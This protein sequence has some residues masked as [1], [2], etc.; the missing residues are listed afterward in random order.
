MAQWLNPLCRIVTQHIFSLTQNWCDGNSRSGFVLRYR[1]DPLS[2]CADLFFWIHTKASIQSGNHMKD[3]LTCTAT[4]MSSRSLEGMELISLGH[5][6]LSFASSLCPIA[7]LCL[8][9][10]RLLA[11]HLRYLVS[12]CFRY[13]P[14][15]RNIVGTSWHGCSG[16]VRVLMH[17]ILHHLQRCFV[18]QQIS[19]NL[20]KNACCE[21][22][23]GNGW[24]Y[25]T[26]DV[27]QHMLPAK[28]RPRL[29][30]CEDLF[31]P[32]KST[33]TSQHQFLNATDHYHLNVAL[34]ATLPACTC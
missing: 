27:G 32:N 19:C 11:L 13:C 5:N 10:M 26:I 4:N 30:W 17:L 14:R 33:P 23:F 7:L 31:S 28:F 20:A 34:L 16:P 9:T 25:S 12:S 3:V 18:E 22:Q 2:L 8:I 24:C 21:N 1:I 29:H 15:L 6:T